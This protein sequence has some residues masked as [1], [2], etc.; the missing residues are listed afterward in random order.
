MMTSIPR[1][2]DNLPCPRVGK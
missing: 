2:S 1:T